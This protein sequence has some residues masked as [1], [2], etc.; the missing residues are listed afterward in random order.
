MIFLMRKVN[1]LPRSWFEYW[2]NDYL[3]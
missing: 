2:T 3:L 1:S